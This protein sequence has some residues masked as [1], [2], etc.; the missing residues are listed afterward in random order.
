M[1]L[2]KDT[3]VERLW[4]GIFTENPVLV[5]ALGMCPTLAT[6][7]SAMNAIG[8]GLSTTVVLALSNLLISLLRNI[9]PKKMRM[10]AYIV[11]IASFVTMIDFLMEGF[12][13]ALYTALGIYIPL[14][15]VNCI[16]MGRAEAYAGKMPPIPAF[17]DGVGMGIGFTAAIF[18]LASLREIIGAG[19]WLGL[20]ITPA[21]YVPVNIFVL[22]PGAFL[23]CGLLVAVMNKLQ[24]GVGR[25][26]KKTWDPTMQLCGNCE[27]CLKFGV[28]DGKEAETAKI[29]EEAKAAGKK[30]LDKIAA[31]KAAAAAKPAAEKLPDAAVQAELEKTAQKDTEKS[32]TQKAVEHITQYIKAEAAGETPEGE[33]DA[34]TTLPKTA[35]ETEF[36]HTEEKMREYVR[37]AREE[38]SAALKRAEDARL[39][40]VRAEAKA[41]ET[42]MLLER[43]EK[44]VAD[45][46]ENVRKALE[47]QESFKAE[48]EKLAKAR[49]ERERALIERM[50]AEN[51]AK[52][53]KITFIEE[54]KPVINAKQAPLG[55]NEEKKGKEE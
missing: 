44:D 32:E 3:P 43:A 27:T 17:F 18:V 19:T 46:R 42:K 34:L 1:K 29:I 33:R 12:T 5:L 36:E 50:A 49:D 39:E 4:N 37:Y 52:A 15:V 6:T 38:A 55:S 22:A 14:I 47:L 28:C 25:K 11:V 23:V 41:R 24:I 35:E 54:D 48:K 7:T 9:I 51:L 53:G 13:P 30:D 21:G 10:P 8:M 31:E 45:A 16:I 20:K 2:K 26:D 40:A